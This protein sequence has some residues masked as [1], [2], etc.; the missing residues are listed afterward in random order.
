MVSF[1]INDSK[2]QNRGG[3]NLIKLKKL[4]TPEIPVAG[5]VVGSRGCSF[6]SIR[7]RRHPDALSVVCLCID[8]IRSIIERARERDAQA[9]VIDQCKLGQYKFWPVYEG[10]DPT[11]SLS[12]FIL[13]LQLA[14]PIDKMLASAFFSASN[15]D[16][17]SIALHIRALQFRMPGLSSGIA[18][19]PGTPEHEGRPIPGNSVSSSPARR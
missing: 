11:F 9:V 6:L 5:R 16:S 1:A 18:P 19:P 4:L 15:V 7:V 13:A 2:Y 10:G 8:P 12:F 14:T 3:L 17:A